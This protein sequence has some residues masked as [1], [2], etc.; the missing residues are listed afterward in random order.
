MD[1]NDF[2]EKAMAKRILSNHRMLAQGIRYA[3][4]AMAIALAGC[5]SKSETVTVATNQAQ[6]SPTTPGTPTTPTT[7]TTPATPAT[8]VTPVVVGNITSFS[9]SGGNLLIA[10]ANTLVAGDVVVISG[11]ATP[12]YNGVFTIV[13][14]TAS[15]FTIAVPFSVSDTISSWSKA[16]GLIAGCTT[17]TVAGS[18]AAVTLPSIGTIPSR[19]TGVAPLS[20]FFDLTSTTSPTSFRLSGCPKC[21]QSSNDTLIH[22]MG[23]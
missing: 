2:R 22:E 10:S 1:C 4:V 13:S 17:N 9:A 7:P 20:V 15:G 16:G 18:A 12:A 6:G 3:I 21:R 11:S 5:G 8:P 23:G 19:F 14:A